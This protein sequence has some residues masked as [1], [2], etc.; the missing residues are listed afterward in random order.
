MHLFLLS[1]HSFFF[2][3]AD[4]NWRIYE[5]LD[6]FYRVEDQSCYQR[7][8]FLYLLY[9][10]PLDSQKLLLHASLKDEREAPLSHAMYDE[11]GENTRQM[12][13]KQ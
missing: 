6:V 12:K 5:E 11:E 3:F 2:L 7:S 9:S 4:R 13:E 1:L 8:F 10:L